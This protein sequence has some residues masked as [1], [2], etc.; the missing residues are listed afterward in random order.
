MANFDLLTE[1]NPKDKSFVLDVA[2]ALKNGDV[3]MEDLSLTAKDEKKDV[4]EVRIEEVKSEE[5]VVEGKDD[6]MKLK[7]ALAD[8]ILSAIDVFMKI[9]ALQSSEVT[10]KKEETVSVKSE[11][12]VEEKPK[13][14][15]IMPRGIRV[16][17]KEEQEDLDLFNKDTEENETATDFSDIEA[18]YEKFLNKGVVNYYSM[19]SFFVT[20]VGLTPKDYNKVMPS[21][22]IELGRKVRAYTNAFKALKNPDKVATYLGMSKSEFPK[23]KTYARLALIKVFKQEGLELETLSIFGD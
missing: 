16:R 12:P 7:V 6:M 13:T 8:S 1:L 21:N 9:K 14:E 11:E 23:D 3:S 10:E 5:P 22:K 4:S 2:T 15:G 20:T 19:R 18:L 17:S